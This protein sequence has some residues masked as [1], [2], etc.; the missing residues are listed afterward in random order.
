M[1]CVKECQTVRNARSLLPGRQAGTEYKQVQKS[2]H[3]SKSKDLKISRSLCYKIAKSQG[4]G[5]QGYRKP[6]GS[7]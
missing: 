5:V 3:V 4:P 1:Q 2:N 6:I 7:L